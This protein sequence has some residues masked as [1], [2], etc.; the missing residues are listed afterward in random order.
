MQEQPIPVSGKL[1]LSEKAYARLGEI[2]TEPET[3]HKPAPALVKLLGGRLKRP[4]RVEPAPETPFA[5]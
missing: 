1:E 4:A 2:L 5:P 3:E